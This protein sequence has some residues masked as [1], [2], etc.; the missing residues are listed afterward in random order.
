MN[1]RKKVSLIIYRFR[2][3]GLEIFLLNDAEAQDKW[4]FPQSDRQGQTTDPSEDM[5]NMIALDPVQQ[6]DGKL[7]EGWAVE[8]DWHEIPSLKSLLYEDAMQLKDKFEE[9]EQ[10]TFIHLKDA[11]KKV[12]P[13]Q[14]EMLKELKDILT[15]RNSVKDL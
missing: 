1:L 7:E 4:A 2:E 15:D 9:M 13:H 10:G 8:G 3:R 6:E 14:Y 5:D 11:L 12:L